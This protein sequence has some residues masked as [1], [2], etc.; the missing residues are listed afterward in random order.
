MGY[1][2]IVIGKSATATAPVT[3][4]LSVWQMSRI[5]DKMLFAGAAYCA[6]PPGFDRDPADQEAGREPGIPAYKLAMLDGGIIVPQEIR[7][8]L[9]ALT[10]GPDNE[11]GH[12]DGIWTTWLNFLRFAALN[13]GFAVE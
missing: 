5:R 9:C 12:P 6:E 13:G 10:D 3:L 7:E 8:A 1:D 11:P 4:H 2:L